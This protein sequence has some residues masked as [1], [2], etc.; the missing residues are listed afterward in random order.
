MTG[1]KRRDRSASRPAMAEWRPILLMMLLSFAIGFS[2][3]W[4]RRASDA[5]V[6]RSLDA[7]RAVGPAALPPERSLQTAIL[8][9]ARVT[10]PAPAPVAAA[11]MVRAIPP[12]VSSKDAEDPA[13]TSVPADFN[14]FN[15]RNRHRFE[16]YVLNRAGKP[17][18]VEIETKT[19]SNQRPS[20]LQLDLAPGERREFTSQDGLDLHSNDQL[21]LHSP[22]Y[23]D[24]TIAVP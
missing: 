22:P 14:V 10:V 19:D 2:V 18:S 1:P 20:R 13:E 24:L 7:A 12:M 3:L 5:A 17:L 9:N 21:V 23:R 6:V 4:W 11:R 16:G 15:R 8:V